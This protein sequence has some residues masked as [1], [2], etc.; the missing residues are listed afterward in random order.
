MDMLRKLLLL[1]LLLLA[2]L[3]RARGQAISPLPPLGPGD[4]YQGMTRAIPDARVVAP[5]GLEVAFDKT[6]HLIFPAAIRYVDLGSPCLMAGKAEGGAENVLRVKAAVEGFERE[7]NL[8]VICDDGSF[9]SFNVRYALEPARLNVEMA[10]FLHT[11]NGNLPTNRQ[12]LYFHELGSAAP[13]LVR[14]IMESLWRKDERRIKHIGIEEFGVV[15]SL[16]GIYSQGGL[17]YLHT[18]IENRA[19]VDFPVDFV[20]FRVVDRAVLPRTAIQERALAPAR[21]YAVP[22]VVPAGAKARSIYCLGLFS[23][24]PD[25][26][27]EVTLYERGGGRALKYWVESGD[28]AHAR[29]L[30]DLKLTL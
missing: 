24:P 15:W 2:L 5:Y 28:L 20:A 7:T 22:E 6:V 27:L 16:R 30:T 29:A 8:G 14:M 1:L 4:L 9:Y 10:D 13:T 25:K 19:G 3:A 17:L 12:D 26:R 23:L 21:A 18:Q 11:A